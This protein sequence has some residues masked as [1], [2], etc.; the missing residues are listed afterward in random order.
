MKMKKEKSMER[1]AMLSDQGQV[2]KFT[3]ELADFTRPRPLFDPP[4]EITIKMLRGLRMVDET[5]IVYGD[6]K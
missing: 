4:M 3:S 6:I 5:I 2:W 1:L